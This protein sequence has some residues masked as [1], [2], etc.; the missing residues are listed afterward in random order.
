MMNGYYEGA[1]HAGTYHTAVA[2][3]DTY[4]DAITIHP[5]PFYVIYDEETDHVDFI[6]DEVFYAPAHVCARK[7]YVPGVQGDTLVQVYW[8]FDFFTTLSEDFEDFENTPFNWQ[9]NGQYP[10]TVVEDNGGHAFR[11]SNAGQASTT[12]EMQVTVVIPQDGE[13][14]FDYNCQGE[15][16]YTYWDHCDFELDGTTIFTH[17]ADLTGWQ[18]YS[19]P[20]TQGTHTFKWSYTKDS[21]V[22]PTGDC[23]TIDN[24]VFVGHEEN[25]SLH[26]YNIYRTDCYFPG[27]Y[28]SDN[29]EF[30]ATAWVPD[31]SYFDVSWPVTPVGVYKW[32]VS[33]VY[34]GNN[35][36]NPNNGLYGRDEEFTEYPFEERESEIVWSDLCAPCLDK[37]MYLFNEVSVN[38]V[39][40]SADSPEGVTVS[41]L[42]LMP[43]EQANYPQP[44]VILDQTGH[45]VFPSF[46][47]GTYMVTVTMP[48]YYTLEVEEPIWEPRDLR[49]VLTEIIYKVQN[50]YVSRTGWAMWEPMNPGM[51]PIPV[52]PDDP[53]GGETAFSFSFDNGFDGWTTI[54][55]D[56]DGL[57]WVN[58]A[59]SVSA[60]GY[61]Y[62]GLAH[63]GDYFVYSQSYI[64]YDG[65]Y[66]ADNYLVSPQKYA[67]VNGSTLTFWADNAN[68]SYPDHLAIAIATANNPTAADFTD[69]WSHTGA[70]S[71]GRMATRHIENRYN[72]WRQHSVDL[73]AYAGQ[74]VWIAF[75]HE[76]YD[77]YEIWIDDVTL[78]TGREERHLEAYKVM[79]TSIDGE[80]IFNTNTPADQPFCQLA[81]NNPDALVNGERYICAV[82]AIYSTGMSEYETV[83]WEYETCEH[84]AG[85]VDG[86]SAE[87]N[88]ITWTYPGGGVNPNPNPGEASTFNFD[89]EGGLPEGWTVIDGNNDGYTWCLTSAIPTTWTYYASLSLDWYH[90]GTNAI[91][92]GSYINGV[93]AVNPDEYFVLPVVNIVNGSQLSFW[94]AA[95]DA[96]YPAD[97]FGVFVSDNGTSD[98][99]SVQE[100][101]LT[102][103]KSGMVGGRASRDGDGLRLGTWYNY[104]VDLSAYAGQKYIAFRHFNCYDQYIMCLDDIT[105]SVASKAVAAPLTSASGR[106]GFNAAQNGMISRDGWYYYDN[107]N[108]E[109]AIGTGGG[110]FWWAIM[111]PA[112]SYEGNTLTK[113][114]AYDYMAMTGDVTIYNDGTNAPANAV[115]TTNVTF[116]GSEDFVE[117]TF[118]TPVTI[119]PTKNVWVV[120]HNA[121]GATYPAA[122]CANTG[123]ANGRWVTLDGITWED[124]ADYGLSYTFMVRA[125]LES[126]TTPVD[127]V[128]PE[129]G[130]GIVGAMIF[131]DGEWEAFVPAPTNTYTYEGEGNEILVRIVYDGPAELPSNNYYYAM[132]CGESY[133]FNPEPVEPACEAGAPLFAEVDNGTDRVHLW[134]SEQPEPVDPED[135]DTFV[136]DF[137]NSSLNGLTLIDADGD[138]NNW[139]L[140]SVAMSTGYGHNGS[141]DMIL[142]KSYDNNIGALTPDNYIVFPQ[143]NIVNGSTFSFWACGQDAGWASEHFGVAVSTQGN[144]SAAD[145]TTIAEWTMTAKG[146]KAVRDGRDQGNWYQ[147]TV[148]LSDYAGEQVYIALRHF[149]CTDMFYLDVD[150]V[151]LSIAAKRDV[152]DIIGYNIYRSEDGI[153][154]ELIATVDG[155]VYEY[156]DTPDAGTYY[157]QVTAL[158]E[159]CESEPAVSGLDPDSNY[160]MVGVTGIGEN[161]AN[162]NLFPNPTK[163]NVTIQALNMNRITVVSVLGQVVFDTE[164]DQDEYVLNMAQ[165]NTGMYM[166]RVYTDNGVSVKRVTVMH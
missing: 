101:T 124:I 157:Y 68:D 34:S 13:F 120:F 19:R 79:C 48:G 126:G 92:S 7:M 121:S 43:Q 145:F 111:L 161:S 78:T 107:G 129:V 58:S 4:Q 27:E 148:D 158:Y 44:S 142:S 23:F 70:K 99:T 80:P 116:T 54:D 55:N 115:G 16:T 114:A 63:T 89:F 95:T 36:N 131:V 2:T 143:S 136:Y 104:T 35:P 87:G 106:T 164:L 154:Y 73:S 138:G 45:Y 46:R 159:G 15:G 103:K 18:H 21:S 69:I 42:N 149:N 123:D 11:S 110:E 117:F 146:A 98:W 12:S 26:H 67:I 52:N 66:D 24:I 1:V 77:E 88:T 137:E 65:A 133:E 109:D 94:V 29:T 144:T 3:M 118:A 20:I 163:G 51:P 57:T 37:D 83:E 147:Y 25:R 47:K 153:T 156:F 32:G 134:W 81:I 39:L 50:L 31:T 33:A 59:N 162:V 60:S 76:D 141:L 160:V 140:G 75:H 71:E 56:G 53:T 40:N 90:S 128:D 38:V 112:G 85:T 105:L 150:D 9:N 8:D 49:Y 125:Y 132:S 72:N 166:V 84:Y 91:C 62:T 122:V 74:N 64:D 155:D 130:E 17:G 139:V 108:N 152:N 61:D 5:L 151:E 127:P 135:G 28:N 96:S 165:F 86:V 97:H 14:S 93:G 102:A 22:N 10:W 113:V 119:D 100:W 41:F 82:A 6:M 30:L